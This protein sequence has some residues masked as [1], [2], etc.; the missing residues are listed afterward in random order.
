MT[1]S[2][3]L[4]GLLTRRA[5]SDA[6]VITAVTH[7][8]ALDRPEA[9]PPDVRFVLAASP[10]LRT[11]LQHLLKNGYG[12]G[13][14]TLR[15]TPGRILT[16]IDRIAERTQG[17]TLLPWLPTLL[18]KEEVP[19]FTREELE[20]AHA[21]GID[22]Y[23]EARIIAE[24]RDTFRKLVLIDLHDQRMSD[25][26]QAVLRQANAALAPFA[27]AAMVH[28]TLLDRSR[29][30]ARLG[31]TLAKAVLFIGP[32]AHF[33]ERW[34][35]GFGIVVAAVAD[36]LLSEAAQ[37]ITLRQSGMTRRQLRTRIALVL[38]PLML[39]VLLAWQVTP[40]LQAGNVVQAGMLFGAA[41]CMRP[42]MQIGQSIA[43]Y[44]AAYA[45]LIRERKVLLHPGQSSWS[46]AMRQT[47]L[48]TTHASSVIGLILM[49]LVAAGAF[50]LA[51]PHVTNGWLLALV[52]SADI[53]I[54]AILTALI[55]PLERWWLH[56]RAL[57][58]LLV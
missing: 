50:V 5:P 55:R 45:A 39:A 10:E 15:R 2:F 12:I 37:A 28:R 41:A 24:E 32:L 54:A 57:Q 4:R 43:T 51:G 29:T 13:V 35:A 52:A 44:R 3:I 14:R 58:R 22:L 31:D 21:D 18:E 40:L 34:V 6:Y 16:A 17:N 53:M 26:H 23:E 38:P 8:T 56:R 33:L 46:L 27:V 19:L 48:D 9:L 20:Q 49:P 7:T 36:D 25:A 47:L 11:P 30:E 1:P 42:L